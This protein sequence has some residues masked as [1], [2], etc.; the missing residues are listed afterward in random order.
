MQEKAMAT[1]GITGSFGFDLF[2]ES[3]PPIGP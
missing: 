2:V 3:G 1:N